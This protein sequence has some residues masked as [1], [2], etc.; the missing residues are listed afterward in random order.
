MHSDEKFLPQRRKFISSPLTLGLASAGV[1]GLASARADAV[2]SPQKA[3]SLTR[4]NSRWPCCV[5][6]KPPRPRAMTAPAGMPMLS[7]SNR[8]PRR[9]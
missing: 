6:T 7:G 9:S 4:Q 5:T 2:P 8:A 1:L 3:D